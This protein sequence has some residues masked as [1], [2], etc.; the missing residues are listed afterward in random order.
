MESWPVIAVS[1]PAIAVSVVGYR[2]FVWRDPGYRDLTLTDRPDW[3]Q[4]PTAG[5]GE[6]R[7]GPATGVHLLV[8]KQW[9][10]RKGR[11]ERLLAAAA[12]GTDV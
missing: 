7:A 8:R 3:R 6:R 9:R 1:L 12:H 5:A 4:C 11:T 10:R 2:L